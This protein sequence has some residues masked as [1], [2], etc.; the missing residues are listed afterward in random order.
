M[1]ADG[2]RLN[3]WERYGWLMP[4]VW[5]VFLAYTVFAVLGAG[6]APVLTALGLLLVVLFGAV[7]LA[8]F[9][10][11]QGPRDYRLRFR[12]WN[13]VGLA[14]LCA[15]IAAAAPLIGFAALFMSPYVVGYACYIL[16]RK[17]GWIVGLG[18]TAGTTAL[19][20]LAGMLPEYL[21]LVF[22]MLGVFVLNTAEAALLDSESK[23]QAVSRDLAVVSERER[24]ARDVHDGL[25]HT[26]TVVA[27]KA[28]LAER[29][30]DADPARARAEL[31]ELHGLI[32]DALAEVRATVGGLRAND[33]PT[34]A[35]ALRLALEGA[36]I[37]VVIE[38]DP[39][40]VRTEL[41]ATLG[42]ILRE[43]GT[44]VLRHARAQRCRL[45]F[46]PLRMAVEDD[47][48]GLGSAPAG[49]GRRG[50]AERVDEAGASLRV[51]PGTGGGTRVE[52]AW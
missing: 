5:L 7:Y 18:A 8:A 2:P 12:H 38:G 20:A 11:L 10:V 1:S 31:G 26:L 25:G 40:G 48:V 43:A 33:L 32:R 27:M 37:D 41:Q 30:M 24:V 23:R 49:H 19:L 29:I 51:S 39:A 4:G 9:L 50:M 35:S 6:L 3:A 21:F 16:P 36:G 42:W 17:G 14:V 44:N 22:I 28:E 52:V 45:E 34:Q 13:W 47:G 46:S 15:I